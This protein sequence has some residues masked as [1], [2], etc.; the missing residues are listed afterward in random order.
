MSG[1]YNRQH[2]Q[3]SNSK[4][5]ERLLRR[6]MSSASVRMEAVEVLRRR[7]GGNM[8]NLAELHYPGFNK[9]NDWRRRNDED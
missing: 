8:E 1:K 9:R 6:G 2:P 4:Y 7:Q 3:R 5:P